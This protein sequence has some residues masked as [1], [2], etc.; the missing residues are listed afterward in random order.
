MKIYMLTRLATSKAS[1]TGSRGAV[2]R[3][4][5]RMDDIQRSL[6]GASS[7]SCRKIVDSQS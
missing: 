7:F 2:P 5:E 4:R 1:M 3:V 6:Y